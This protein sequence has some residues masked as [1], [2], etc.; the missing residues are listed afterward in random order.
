[1]VSLNTNDLDEN[2]LAL[3]FQS[4]PKQCIILFEDVDQASIQKCNTDSHL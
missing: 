1:M 2:G 3:L 4:L